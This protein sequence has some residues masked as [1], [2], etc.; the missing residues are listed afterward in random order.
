MVA[1]VLTQHSDDG[2]GRARDRAACAQ[3]TIIQRKHSTPSLDLV[4]D[5]A[6]E[7]RAAIRHL[8]HSQP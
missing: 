8:R 5:A 2:L 7:V 6:E 4:D 1:R 3:H